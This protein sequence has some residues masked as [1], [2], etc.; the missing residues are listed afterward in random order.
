L[1]GKELAHPHEI[2]RRGTIHIDADGAVVMYIDKAG[3]SNRH[4]D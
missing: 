3:Q 4:L 2:F 1:R